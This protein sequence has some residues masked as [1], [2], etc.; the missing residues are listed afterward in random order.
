V[1]YLTAY[2]KRDRMKIPL[3]HQGDTMNKYFV[4]LSQKKPKQ[5]QRELGR[6]HLLVA[7][8]AFAIIVLLLQGSMY[9]VSYDLVLTLITC[10]LLVVVVL[11]SLLV[12]YTCFT[13]KK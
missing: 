12:S 5:L 2:H 13:K 10:L 7:A 4:K 8:L 3:G 9:P 6:A 1:T 11:I